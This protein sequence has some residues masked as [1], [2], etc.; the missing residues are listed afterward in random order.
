MTFSAW[1]SARWLVVLAVA[2]STIHPALAQIPTT[3][4][5]AVEVIG[6]RNTDGQVCVSLFNDDSGFP[7]DDS[8]AIAQQCVELVS[9]NAPIGSAEGAS[10]TI[11]ITFKDLRAST[12]AVSV[13]HDEDEDQQIGQG[14]F[15][16]PTEGFGFSRN[17]I[18][19]TGAPEFSET[20]IFVLGDTATQ[21]DLI[22]F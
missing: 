7:N 14:A 4:T 13:L 16:V 1:F 15:G 11:S 10:S 3:G 20:A 8:A 6:L 22:Y 18:I 12:Y 9:L 5:L 19:R 17:P 21:I 2:S